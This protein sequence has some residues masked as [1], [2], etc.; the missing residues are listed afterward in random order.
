VAIKINVNEKGKRRPKQ[1]S[2]DTIKNDTGL[3]V[4]TKEIWEI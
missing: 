2:L 3:L 1:R 4:S